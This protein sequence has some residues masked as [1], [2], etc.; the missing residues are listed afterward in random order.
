M[1]ALSR[2][3][4]E[5]LQNDATFDGILNVLIKGCWIEDDHY[6]HALYQNAIEFTGGLHDSFFKIELIGSQLILES[7]SPWELEV[8]TSELKEIAA[9][10]ISLVIS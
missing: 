2:V 6:E 9:K 7:D 5:L 1:S 8:L 4:L 10:K 3:E